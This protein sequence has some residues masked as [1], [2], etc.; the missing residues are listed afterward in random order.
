MENLVKRGDEFFK[1][2]LYNEAIKCYREYLL[3]NPSDWSL[4]PKIA[5]GLR[6]LEIFDVAIEFY[7]EALKLKPEY[8]YGYA[9]IGDIYAFDLNNYEKAIEYYEK[10]IKKVPDNAEAYNKIATFYK[11]IDK[12]STFDKQVEYFTKA[13]ELKPDFIGAIRNLAVAYYINQQE[14]KS[15]QYFDKLFELNGA[16]EDDY[17]VY[18][19]MKIKLGDFEDGWKFYE[20]RFDKLLGKTYYPKMYQPRWEG[21]NIGDKTLLVHFEQGL[22]DSIQFFRYIKLLTPY[23]KKMIFRV[24][25]SL[26]DLF[27][28][29]ADGFEVVGHAT[30]LCDIEFDYHIPLLSIIHVLGLTKDEIPSPEGYIVAD[31]IKTKKFKDDYFNNDKFKIAI[32]WHGMKGGNET[33][34]ALLKHFYPI[35]KLKNVQVYSFQKYFGAEELEKLPD[36]VNIIDRGKNFNDFSDTAAAMA[37]MDL[38]ITTDNGAFHV[39]AAMGVKT[40]LLLNYRAEWRWFYDDDKTPWYSSVRIFKKKTM[41]ETWE[42]LVERVISELNR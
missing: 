28:L 10:Y 21:Q 31:K 6:K 8:F 16:V 37:N 32:M 30:P 40:F 34:D 4:Y 29:N 9:V 27:K 2:G 23:A 7:D 1:E 42:D 12:F 11:K 19:C 17:F 22:G 39:A 26:V 36:D 14:E 13:I 5:E 3:S 33:R 18:A 25:D 15:L 41:D 20:K 35:A 38:C 24:Q